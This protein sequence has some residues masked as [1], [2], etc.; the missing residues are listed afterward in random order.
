MAWSSV[1]CYRDRTAEFR[2]FSEK[3][4]R[5]ASTTATLISSSQR[6]V[7][8]RSEFNSKASKIGLAI[9]ETS[10]KV[11][12]LA[13][14]AKRS[15]MFSDPAMEI[16]ELTALIKN[17]ITA[18]NAAVSDLQVIQNM[19]ATDSNWS[20]DG[21]VHATTICDD[22]KNRLMRATKEFKDVLTTRTKNLKAHEDRKKIFSTNASRENAFSNQVKTPTEPP[23]WSIAPNTTTV[24]PSSIMPTSGISNGNQLRRRLAVENT[25]SHQ[26]EMTVV[27]QVVPQQDN[28]RQGRAVALQNVESTISELGGIFT[29]LATMVAQQGELAIRLPY[30]APYCYFM[31]YPIL[32]SFPLMTDFL[33]VV[34]R[35]DFFFLEICCNVVLFKL[36]SHLLLCLCYC[37]EME[38]G[39]M[40][41]KERHSDCYI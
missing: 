35:D 18:L 21:V 31:L 2:S 30:Y 39:L 5:S 6:V 3:I 34:N 33:Q 23:P 11:A 1:S 15:S 20:S 4:K 16:Q 38:L 37:Q 22:L 32:F 13:K 9:Y 26:V 12:R 29:Q 27:Q 25:P 17:D 28:Y 7:T 8:S 41:T 40:T 14:L 36:C 24:T 19:E 10:Q